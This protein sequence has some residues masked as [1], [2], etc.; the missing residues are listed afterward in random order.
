M[1]VFNRHLQ[2]IIVAIGEIEADAA[3]D[4]IVIERRLCG[5]PGI[6]RQKGA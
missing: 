1:A 2:F 4:L 3:N 6:E 5:K